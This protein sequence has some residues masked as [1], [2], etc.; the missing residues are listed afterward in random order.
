MQSA[1]YYKELKYYFQLEKSGSASQRLHPAI[2]EDLLKEH[3]SI[4]VGSPT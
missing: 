3:D 1:E 4:N 2:G